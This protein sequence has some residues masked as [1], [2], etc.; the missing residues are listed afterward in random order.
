MYCEYKAHVLQPKPA[1]NLS[2][3]K[4]RCSLLIPCPLLA[5]YSLAAG[6]PLFPEER[7]MDGAPAGE[8]A[9]GEWDALDSTGNVF[10]HRFHYRVCGRQSQRNL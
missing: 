8:E 9:Q 7:K 4:G 2:M 1:H 6:F 3:E 5:H 10:C